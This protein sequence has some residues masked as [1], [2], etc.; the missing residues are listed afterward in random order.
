[1]ALQ[2]SSRHLASITECEIIPLGIELTS[3]LKDSE[4]QQ[5]D[6]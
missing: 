3:L 6:Y 1:M 2:D 4:A 5:T